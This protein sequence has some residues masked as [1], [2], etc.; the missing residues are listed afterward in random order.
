MQD[1]IIRVYNND[2]PGFAKP[3]VGTPEHTRVADRILTV[4]PQSS[5]VRAASGA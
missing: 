4:V 2:G 3:L 1:R 5:V